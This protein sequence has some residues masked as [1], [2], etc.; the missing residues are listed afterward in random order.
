MRNCSNQQIGQMAQR[1]PEQ[2]VEPLPASIGG[3]LRGE[4]RQQPAQGLRPVS[5]QAEEVLELPDHAFDDL[6]LARRPAALLAFET[7]A[8]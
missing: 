2:G 1:P 5:L 6:P 8:G 7:G 3:H 4:A